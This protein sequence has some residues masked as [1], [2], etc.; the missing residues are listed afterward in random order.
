[1]ARDVARDMARDIARD[2]AITEE[3]AMLHDIVLGEDRAVAQ[4]FIF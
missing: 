1:M 2:T 4:V 3:R